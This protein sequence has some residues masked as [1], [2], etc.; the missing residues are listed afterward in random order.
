MFKNATES[1]E[2]IQQILDE[3]KTTKTCRQLRSNV[4]SMLIM[5]GWFVFIAQNPKEHAVPGKIELEIFNKREN[6]KI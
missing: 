5:V 2:Q 3:Q 6:N 1:V 4:T